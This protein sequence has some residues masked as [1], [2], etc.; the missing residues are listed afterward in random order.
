[1]KEASSVVTAFSDWTRIYSVVHRTRALATGS[2][3]EFFFQYRIPT[4]TTISCV[5][6]F[7]VGA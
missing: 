5:L 4:V 6:M 7:L 3:R 2:S 1:M